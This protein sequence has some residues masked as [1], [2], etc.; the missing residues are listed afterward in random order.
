MAQGVRTMSSREEGS[1]RRRI[2]HSAMSVSL[3]A[4]S[5]PGSRSRRNAVC[6]VHRQELTGTPGNIWVNE[7]VYDV[8]AA[9]YG[10]AAESR[11]G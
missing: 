11:C 10:A 3:G 7:G 1:S 6:R 2:R 4:D 5:W 8:A 9:A